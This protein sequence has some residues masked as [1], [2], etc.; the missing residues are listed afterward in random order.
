M[1]ESYFIAS[2][3]DRFSQLVEGILAVEVLA[4]ATS[5]RHGR[6][7]SLS[8]RISDTE[9]WN[10]GTIEILRLTR[11][12]SRLQ[13]VLQKPEVDEDTLSQWTELRTDSDHRT[14]IDAANHGRAI[15]NKILA[16]VPPGSFVIPDKPRHGG[17]S[18]S[19]LLNSTPIQQEAL[20]REV[21]LGACTSGGKGS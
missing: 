20:I 14:S 2:R 13:N 11:L 12:P 3:F 15:L 8:Y 10:V 16:A 9:T 5:I 4:E 21:R 17:S 1:S 18:N 7:Y 19:L 6:K